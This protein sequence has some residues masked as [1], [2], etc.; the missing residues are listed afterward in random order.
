MKY[1]HEI[2]YKMHD[3]AEAANEAAGRALERLKRVYTY[4]CLTACLV[5]IAI[6][7]LALIISQN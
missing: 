2:T 7:T 6:V 3:N 5:F 4:T 1:V